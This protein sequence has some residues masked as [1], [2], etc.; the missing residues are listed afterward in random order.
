M[1]RSTVIPARTL[2]TAAELHAGS[3][4]PSA[5]ASR[6]LG[7]G[8]RASMK[9]SGE[10]V[11]VRMRGRLEMRNEEAQAVHS[12]QEKKEPSEHGTGARPRDR[13]ASRDSVDSRFAI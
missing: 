8:A 7:G 13:L 10:A 4:R 11:D 5:R 6:G 12:S 3:H 9:P 1:M 2:S